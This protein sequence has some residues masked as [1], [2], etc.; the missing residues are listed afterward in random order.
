[1]FSLA[2]ACE[3]HALALGVP[4]RVRSAVFALRVEEAQQLWTL[5]KAPF[6]GRN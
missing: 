5:V 6:A 3:C 4:E 2:V 1:M